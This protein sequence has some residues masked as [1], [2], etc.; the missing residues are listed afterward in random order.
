MRIQS[1]VDLVLITARSICGF[2]VT[3]YLPMPLPFF[4]K[5]LER[6][7]GSHKVNECIISCKST[8]APQA[9]GSQGIMY[10]PVLMTPFMDFAL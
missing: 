7:M 10:Q 3:L 8:C 9:F 2:N 5:N 4:L 1:K 6:I